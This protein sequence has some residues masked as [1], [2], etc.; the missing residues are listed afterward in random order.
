M[1]IVDAVYSYLPAKR[2]QTPSGW[3]K[4]NAVC[5]HHNGNTADTRARGGIIKNAEGVSYHCFNCGFKASYVA[6][7]HLTRKMKQLLSWMG[8][9]DDAITKL[10]FEALKI[11][12]DEKALEAISLPKFEDRPIPADSIKLSADTINEQTIPAIEYVYSRGLTL[13]DYP[14]YVSAELKDRIIIPFYLDNRVVGYTARKLGDG[15]PKYLSEQTPG[16]V[17]NIDRQSDWTTSDKKYVIVVEGPVD[18][19]SI[20]GVALLGAEIMDKQ[21]MLINRIGKPVIVVPDRDKDGARTVEQAIAQG[22]SVSMPD[23][24]EGVKDTNDAIKQYGKLYTLYS[25]IKAAEQYELKIK[26]RAKTWFK[27]II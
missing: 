12:S 8:A 15:K 4:F 7:R 14:F 6:G 26:L 17:F 10:S 9:S 20:D 5:C 25:I 11:E 1:S 27:E 19:I 3:T 22:W 23:W 16:Y 2:K 18:A 24:D 13:D 21:A